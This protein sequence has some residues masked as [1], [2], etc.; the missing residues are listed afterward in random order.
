[1]LKCSDTTHTLGF[2]HQSRSELLSSIIIAAVGRNRVIGVDGRLPW[3]IPDDMARFR[4]LTTGHALLMGRAT[5][6]SIGRPLPDRTTIV[7]TRQRGWAADGVITA[8]SLDDGL[9]LAQDAG[10][11]CFIAG[12]AEVY[13]E[14]LSVADRME[15]TEVH[16]EPHGDTFFPEVDWGRWDEVARDQ[17]DGFDFVSYARRQGRSGGIRQIVLRT[18]Q[19]LC[20]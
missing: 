6:E 3:R 17:R 16:S 7:L 11:D 14:A 1:M 9:A 8:H 4:S 12:G 5:Y 15:L 20:R 19:H 13:S 18:W 10:V 2:E